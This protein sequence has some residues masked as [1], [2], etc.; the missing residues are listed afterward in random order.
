[1]SREEIDAAFGINSQK[2]EMTWTTYEGVIKKIS[3]L[4]HQHL[5][6]ILY[7][8]KYVNPNYSSYIVTNLL[9]ELYKRFDGYQLP[10]RPKFDWEAEHLRKQGW[11]ISTNL[12]NH[13]NIIIFGEKIGEYKS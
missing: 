13:Y 6:N 2:K 7:F 10:Y 4:D 5:S 8:I 9:K 3:E 12:Q 11:L 1:M